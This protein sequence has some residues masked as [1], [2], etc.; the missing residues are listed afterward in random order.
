[1]F[2]RYVYFWNKTFFS[3]KIKNLKKKDWV[4]KFSKKVIIG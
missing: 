2:L 4:K 3:I 1:M